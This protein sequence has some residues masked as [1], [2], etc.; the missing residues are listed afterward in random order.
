MKKDDEDYFSRKLHARIK[1]NDNSPHGKFHRFLF[2]FS[3]KFSNLN[4]ALYVLYIYLC[5]VTCHTKW[6]WV[7]YGKIKPIQIKVG[8][9]S[10]VIT[11]IKVKE[12]QLPG[13]VQPK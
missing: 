10:V 7:T 3:R 13:W 11:T 2:P 9:W 6:A 5:Y 8:G 4:F 12:A 1:D